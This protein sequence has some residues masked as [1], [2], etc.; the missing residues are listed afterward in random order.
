MMVSVANA[1]TADNSI[2]YKLLVEQREMEKQ[3][4]HSA[5]A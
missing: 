1:A 2:P 4:W 3:T 5:A